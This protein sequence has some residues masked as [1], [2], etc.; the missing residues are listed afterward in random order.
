MAGRP[1]DRDVQEQVVRLAGEMLN[2]TWSL[3]CM[4]M[5]NPSATG[6]VSTWDRGWARSRMWAQYGESH[7]GVCLV[8]DRE[9]MVH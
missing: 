2:E 7:R 9:S 4:T 1:L 8:F 5:D 3:A 6:P